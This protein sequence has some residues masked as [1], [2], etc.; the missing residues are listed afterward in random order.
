MYRCERWINP[1]FTLIFAYFMRFLGLGVNGVNTVNAILYIFIKKYLF[2]FYFIKIE[3]LY[4]FKC[5]K[6]S[7]SPFTLFQKVPILLTF[8]KKKQIFTVHTTPFHRSHYPLSPFT[9]CPIFLFHR[10]HYNLKD[11]IKNYHK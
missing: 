11:T 1:P 3:I 8:Y 4:F 10:S 6:I 5:S 2:F 7:F 9:L